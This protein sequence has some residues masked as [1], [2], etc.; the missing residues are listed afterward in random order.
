MARPRKSNARSVALQVR[1]TPKMQKAVKAV[2]ARQGYTVS[3]WL[4]LML[5]RRLGGE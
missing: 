2:A 4:N 3:S 1:V 5:V